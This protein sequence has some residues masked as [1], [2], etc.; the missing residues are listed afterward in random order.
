MGAMCRDPLAVNVMAEGEGFAICLSATGYRISYGG[1]VFARCV[2]AMVAAEA[3]LCADLDW[4]AVPKSG[5]TP[6]QRSSLK[7][8]FEGAEVRGEILLDRIFPS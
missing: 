3:M 1:R 5:L 2:D 6:R 7:A 4:A 8:I